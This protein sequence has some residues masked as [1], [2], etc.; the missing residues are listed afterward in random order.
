MAA[1]VGKS[2]GNPVIRVARRDR[3]IQEAR[4]DVYQVR[5]KFREPTVCPQCGAVFHKGRWTWGAK[6][7][8]AHETTCP[9]CERINGHNPAGLLTWRGPFVNLHRDELLGLIRNEEAKAKAE[10][11]LA[12]LITVEETVD[13]VLVSTTDMHLAQGIGE[14]LRHAHHGTLTLR[15]S[16][17]QQLIRVR[18]EC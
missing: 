7:A 14:A 1:R 12:R 18:W 4:H 6:P 9:A 11:P 16:K 3:T 8:K 2:N 17:N 13:S 10:H 15:Y 5:G